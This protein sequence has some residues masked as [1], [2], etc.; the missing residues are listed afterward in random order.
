MIE[1]LSTVQYGHKAGMSKQLVLYYIRNNKPLPSVVA[2]EKIAGRNILHTE[3]E[4][5]KKNK[6]KKV[7]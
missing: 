6:S 3:V 1:R 7:A 5:L 4:G 2:I